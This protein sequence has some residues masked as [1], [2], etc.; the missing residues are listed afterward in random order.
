MKRRVSRIFSRRSS[1][2]HGVEPSGS[3]SITASASRDLDTVTVRGLL[4][5][6]P[7]SSAGT[8]LDNALHRPATNLAAL[9]E[10]VE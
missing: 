6:S 1:H 3:A 8:D 4:P 5:V 2:L 9:S 7:R 10:S